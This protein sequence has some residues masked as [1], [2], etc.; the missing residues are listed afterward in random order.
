[1]NKSHYSVKAGI[2]GQSPR[3]PMVLS[4]YIDWKLLN[5]MIGDFHGPTIRTVFTSL[6]FGIHSGS[7]FGPWLGS[8]VAKDAFIYVLCTPRQRDTEI[9]LSTLLR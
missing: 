3:G 1:M 2:C 4:I 8:C 6:E 9:E 7:S 5:H